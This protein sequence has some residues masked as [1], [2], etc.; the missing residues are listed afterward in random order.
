MF[1]L[2]KGSLGYQRFSFFTASIITTPNIRRMSMA[3]ARTAARIY[4]EI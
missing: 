1:Y 3:I 4:D 2:G